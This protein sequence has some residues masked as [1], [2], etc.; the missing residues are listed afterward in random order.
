MCISKKENSWPNIKAEAKKSANNNI[1]K[2]IN[3]IA[4]SS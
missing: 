2:Y 3:K 4:F 1:S